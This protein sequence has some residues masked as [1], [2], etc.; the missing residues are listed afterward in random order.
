MCETPPAGGASQETQEDSDGAIVAQIWP[1][2]KALYSAQAEFSLRGHELGTTTL[3]VDYAH[4]GAARY[5]L[6]DEP[7]ES[8]IQQ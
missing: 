4:R 7:T 3:R 1:D 2:E 6:V 8:E 5:H